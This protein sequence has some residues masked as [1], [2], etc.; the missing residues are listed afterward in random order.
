[1]QNILNTPRKQK[2]ENFQHI[3]QGAYE[4]INIRQEEY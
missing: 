1:M 4:F 3:L 2:R